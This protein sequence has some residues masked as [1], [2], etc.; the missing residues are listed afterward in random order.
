LALLALGLMGGGTSKSPR[1]AGVPGGG[2]P[3]P[4]EKGGAPMTISKETTFLTGPLTEDGYVDYVAALDARFRQGV[5]PANNAAV[6]FWWAMGPK[7]IWAEDREG[8]F[9]KLGVPAPPEQGDYFVDFDDF[10]A[11]QKGGSKHDGKASKRGTEG[12]AWTSRQLETALQ[13][14]WSAREFPLL[15][16]WLAANENPLAL[17]VEASRRPR[18]Y[19]PLIGGK[20]AIVIAVLLPANGQYTFKVGWAMK[21]RAM[22]RLGEG[23]V[24]EAWEDLVA[25]HRLARL[26][27]QGPT[28]VDM[29]GSSGLEERACAGDQALLQ[30]AHLTA[31]QIARFREDLNRLPPM[32]D[33]AD[34]FN[35]AERFVF[36]NVVS[37]GSQDGAKHSL[38]G[39]E[40]TITMQGGVQEWKRLGG[41]V[42]LLVRYSDWTA[43]DWDLILRMGNSWYDRLAQA[44]REPIRSERR[45]ALKRIDEDLHK[46]PKAAE[47]T[48]S[49]EKAMLVDGRRAFSE[50]FGQVLLVMFGPQVTVLADINDHAAM[51]LNLDKLGFAL[52]AY[53]ADHGSFP[54]RLA[55]LMP[56]Y[57]AEVPED[58]FNGSDLHYRR[59]G[60]GFLLY[61]VGTNGRDD[62]A[63][64]F[65]DR[66]KNKTWEALAKDG[67]DWDDLVVRIPPATREK[68]RQ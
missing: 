51:R 11:I 40:S 44:C 63:R 9:Q 13:R 34:T 10:V 21:A 48:A 25:C 18:R 24:N 19:D 41:A 49:L 12:I 29:T 54:A 15:A 5:T 43:A 45:K 55:D 31:A 67:E 8:Y 27:G 61:S 2:G 66:N 26:L 46:L 36:L 64:S 60:A 58:F 14:P 33:L 53:R 62:G 52:A 20:K 7:A 56:K 23:K 30:Y 50:R 1:D 39:L 3:Q 68:E 59:E 17:V 4:S 35:I 16:E 37:L 38:V 22:L 28:S 32:P 57:V 65:E 42:K 47:D 6:P